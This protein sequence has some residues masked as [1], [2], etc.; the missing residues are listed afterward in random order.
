M[1]HLVVGR[2]R[3]PGSRPSAP[4]RVKVTVDHPDTSGCSPRPQR[5][6][7]TIGILVDVDL[8][9]HVRRCFPGGGG[10]LARGR[11]NPA[12]ASTESWATKGI[13]YRF[14]QDAKW[15]GDSRG[16]DRLLAWRDVRASAGLPCRIVSAG[17]SGSYQITADLPGSRNFRPA[18]VSSR[19][20]TTP[21]FA[22]SRATAR[23][24]PSRRR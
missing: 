24:C 5:A 19:A 7:V 6:G 18:V 11:G 20:D 16:A 12:F 21:S 8:G 10:H 15:R 13:P 23:P 22:R 3:P 14:Q 1:A 17:G 9:M 4:G 2:P